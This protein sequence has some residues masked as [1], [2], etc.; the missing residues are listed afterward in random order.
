MFDVRRIYRSLYADFMLLMEERIYPKRTGFGSVTGAK[1]LET[2][3]RGVAD[4]QTKKIQSKVDELRKTLS[5][6][7]IAAFLTEK[8]LNPADYGVVVK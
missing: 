4:A 5:D 7:E 6:E 8:K 3:A 1:E 2:E